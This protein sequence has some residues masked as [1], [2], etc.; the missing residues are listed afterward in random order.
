MCESV[1]ENNLTFGAKRQVSFNW[2]KNKVS[3]KIDEEK[4]KIIFNSQNFG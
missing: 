1:R 3:V 4:E 2:Q